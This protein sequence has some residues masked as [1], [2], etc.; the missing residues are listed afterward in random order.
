MGT[1]S[2]Y[3]RGCQTSVMVQVDEPNHILHLLATVL[4]AGAWLPLWL[5]VSMRAHKH[6][7]TRCG[8][9]THKSYSL[10]AWLLGLP[11][12]SLFFFIA[13]NIVADYLAHAR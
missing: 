2:D 11:L 8:R 5:A 12:L 6:R 1:S 7:C 4:T 3:C 10:G 13:F 9:V